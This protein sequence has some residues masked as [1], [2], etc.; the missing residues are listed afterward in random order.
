LSEKEVKALFAKH[1]GVDRAYLNMISNGRRPVSDSIA[2]AVGLHKVGE[3][4]G[5]N[6]KSAPYPREGRATL[7]LDR[8]VQMPQCWIISATS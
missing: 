1:H 2:G 6:G 8:P 3:G 5:R 7:P 4:K